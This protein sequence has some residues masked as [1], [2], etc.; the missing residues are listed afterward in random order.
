MV[1]GWFVPT[2]TRENLVFWRISIE[3]PSN[4]HQRCSDRKWLKYRAG[5]RP[6]PLFMSGLCCGVQKL[7]LLNTNFYRHFQ[8]EWFIGPKNAFRVEYLSWFSTDRN[9]VGDITWGSTCDTPIGLNNVCC[10][11]CSYRIGRKPR[12][13]AY[14]HIIYVEYPSTL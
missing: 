2:E 9:E 3:Y 10:M 8:L 14:F 4:I 7:R 1:V 5:S 12:F 13:L 6:L 11:V